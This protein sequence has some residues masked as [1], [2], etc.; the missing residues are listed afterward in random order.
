MLNRAD[1]VADG[2]GG[3]VGMLMGL[4]VRWFGRLWRGRVGVR[5]LL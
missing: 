2:A 1:Y 4:E 5:L 3:G